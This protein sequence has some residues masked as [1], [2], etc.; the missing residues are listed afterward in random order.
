[1]ITQDEPTN[2]SIHGVSGLE[3]WQKLRAPT[4]REVGRPLAAE[5]SGSKAV[6]MRQKVE[7]PPT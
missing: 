4:H 6:G 1:M 5:T 7:G 3:N 2:Y